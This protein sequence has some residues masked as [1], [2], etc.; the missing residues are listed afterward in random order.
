MTI[1]DFGQT[2]S[3]WIQVGKGLHDPHHAPWL[4]PLTIT[5]AGYTML[6]ATDRLEWI[7][8][9][10]AFLLTMIQLIASF[11]VVFSRL[12]PV[13][14]VACSLIPSFALQSLSEECLKLFTDLASSLYIDHLFPPNRALQIAQ[15]VLSLFALYVLLA[16]M[17]ADPGISKDVE[18]VYMVWV[19]FFSAL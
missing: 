9:Y 8:Y 2:V 12:S 11:Y 15:F 6:F 13:G 1:V 4:N 19:M 16:M 14:A 10:I 5:P 7:A 3:W 18:H 17:G